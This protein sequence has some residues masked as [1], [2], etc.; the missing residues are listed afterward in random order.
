MK[1]LMHKEKNYEYEEKNIRHLNY[2]I[3]DDAHSFI[4]YDCFRSSV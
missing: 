4:E 3:S 2:I 1:C